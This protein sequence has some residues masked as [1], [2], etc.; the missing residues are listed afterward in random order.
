MKKILFIIASLFVYSGMIGQGTLDPTQCDDPSNLVRNPGFECYDISPGFPDWGKTGHLRLEFGID[1]ENG[2]W[3]VGSPDHYH[4]ASGVSESGIPSHIPTQMELNVNIETDINTPNNGYYGFRINRTSFSG[5]VYYAYEYVCTRLIEPLNPGKSYDVSFKIRLSTLNEVYPQIPQLNDKT[6]FALNEVGLLFS[7]IKTKEVSNIT[8]QSY[9]DHTYY[10]N[11]ELVTVEL[12][13][14]SYNINDQLN[15]RTIEY[16]ITNDGSLPLYYLTVGNFNSSPNFYNKDGQ[17]VN[18]QFTGDYNLRSYYYIDDFLIK[19][20]CQTDCDIFREDLKIT[21]TDCCVNIKLENPQNYNCEG[22]MKINYKNG[23][24]SDYLYMNTISEFKDGIDFCP[25]DYPWLWNINFNDITG[26]TIS[27]YKENGNFLCSKTF[28]YNNCGFKI[29][30]IINNPYEGCCYDL[31]FQKTNLYDCDEDLTVIVEEIGSGSPKPPVSIN[32]TIKICD[33]DGDGII[34]Y[35]LTYL[36]S[37]GSCVGYEEL[38]FECGICEFDCECPTNSNLIVVT[39]TGSDDCPTGCEVKVSLE[40]VDECFNYYKIEEIDTETRVSDLRAYYGQTFIPSIQKCIG[41]DVSRVVNIYLYKCAD[42]P[43]PC[44]ISQSVE[45]DYSCCDFIDVNFLPVDDNNGLCCW[46][47]NI[48]IEKPLLCDENLINVLYYDSNGN[49]VSLVDGKLCLDPNNTSVSYRIEID[50]VVCSLSDEIN[51]VCGNCDCPDKKTRNSW[52]NL[53]VVKGEAPCEPDECKVTGSFEIPDEYASCYDTYELSYE[54]RK[55][56]GSLVFSPY[57]T[58][59]AIQPGLNLLSELPPCISSGNTIQFEIKFIKNGSSDFCIAYSNELFCDQVLEQEITPCF[60]EDPEADELKNDDVKISVNGCEYLVSYEYRRNN[61]TGKQELQI[62]KIEYADPNCPNLATEEELFKEA[63]PDAIGKILKENKKYE[64]RRE[65]DKIVCYSYW[66]LQQH[67]CWSWWDVVG[68]DFSV[69][70]ALVPCESDCCSRKLT[71]CIN[72]DGLISVTDNGPVGDEANTNCF[73]QEPQYQP[74]S[75][76][77]GFIPICISVGCEIYDGFQDDFNP[78]DNQDEIESPSTPKITNSGT[79]RQRE[80]LLMYQTRN[81]NDV[82]TIN[83]KMTKLE[84]IKINIIDIH[85]NQ[86]ESNSF[87]LSGFSQSLKLDISE[88]PTGT[89]YY[90]IVSDGEIISTNKFIIVR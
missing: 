82:L 51:L 6:H 47:P 83:I 68:F 76:V 8:D 14:K 60:D 27:S 38:E 90:N 37:S 88:L 56:D 70:K 34:K 72:G 48:N 20:T 39:E 7:N 43:N 54:I 57:S 23:W 13:A 33:D 25:E 16:T 59:G 36:N 41:K 87:A 17:I 53:E 80:T 89:Y 62:T 31:S 58:A 5:Y 11:S 21:Q 45:C 22:T 84:I 10:T 79:D 77:D 67:T 66:R 64:P 15:W 55:G 2:W 69:T 32:G 12:P 74:L 44:V 24:Q 29:D 35:S 1:S 40:G 4:R 42:D 63:L 26:F 50:G 81:T 19:E 65:K 78:N 18:N 75:A 73:L 86:F 3:G 9:V 30:P 28:I 85:S 71:V 52:V 46:T 61:K 49:P